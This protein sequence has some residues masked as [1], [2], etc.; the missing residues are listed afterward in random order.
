[1]DTVL[2]SANDAIATCGTPQPDMTLVYFYT[3][4]EIAAEIGI[5]ISHGNQDPSLHYRHRDLPY[6]LPRGVFIFP[7]S[8]R[9]A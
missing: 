4:V 2:P 7:R 8:A 3:T 6:W 5:H 1:M 9:R